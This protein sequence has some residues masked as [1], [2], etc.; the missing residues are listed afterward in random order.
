MDGSLLVENIRALCKKNKISITKLEADLF[1]SPGLISRWSRNVPALDKIMDIA[2]Y[3]NVSLDELVG[4]SKGT[5]DL[6]GR[7]LI[8]L[9]NR[10]LTADIAWEIL[11]FQNPCPPLENIK[12]SAFLQKECD[13]YF[14]SYMSGYFFLTI[15]HSRTGDLQLTL[16]TLPDI[17]SDPECICSDTDS[18]MPIYEHLNRLY[19]KQM[20]RVKTDNFIA[21][22]INDSETFSAPEDEKITPM[23]NHEASNY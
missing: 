23:R 5:S 12:P 4:H 15:G 7:L 8:T 14:T 18:L 16:F 20:N 19:S 9:E 1:L 6:T 2:D 13:C 10:T 3:F 17:Y 21:A 22:F 11:D